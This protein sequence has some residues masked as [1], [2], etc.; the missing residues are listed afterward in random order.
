MP[1]VVKHSLLC[2]LAELLLGSIVGH[3][4]VQ[5]LLSGIESSS[6]H[7]VVYIR[8]EQTVLNN[9]IRVLGLCVG[10]VGLGHEAYGALTQTE[11]QPVHT[12]LLGSIVV[13]QVVSHRRLYS[14]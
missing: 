12:E 7:T 4:A 14:A 2:L 9:R 3:D 5:L 6:Y 8:E 11:S 13:E 10:V 1:L